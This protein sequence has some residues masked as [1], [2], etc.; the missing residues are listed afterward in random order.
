MSGDQL[1]RA[2]ESG[3]ERD[4]Y[5][6]IVAKV[7]KNSIAH[8]A[9]IK[10]GDRV[11]SINDHILT[12]LIDYN[13]MSPDSNIRVLVERG[14]AELIEFDIEKDYG[15]DLGIE[16][17]TPVFDSISR[18]ANNCIF[19]FMD[20]M[21]EGLRR[22]LYLKDE[23]YRL[24]FLYG[25]FITMT[26]MSEEDFER[27]KAFN[28]SPLYISVHTTNQKLRK[29]IL[30]SHKAE[31]IMKQLEELTSCGIAIHTQVV[32]MPGVNDGEELVK[33]IEDLSYFYP[34]LESIGIV[35]VGLTKYREDLV[36]LRLFT[37]KEAQEVINMVKPFQAKFRRRFDRGLV[38]LADEFYLMC[39]APLPEND[40]YDDFPQ[41]ENGIGIVRSFYEEYRQAKSRIPHKLRY[42]KEY[43][44]VT[45][46]SGELALKNIVHDLNTRVSGLS[47]DIA[48]VENNFFG[49]GVTVTGL[50]T[51]ADLV[52]HFA[53]DKKRVPSHPLLVPKVML[54]GDAF[55]DDMTIDDVAAETGCRIEV[56]GS[57]FESL[58][59]K[60]SEN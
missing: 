41:Y 56:V 40:E 36:D 45:G 53:A 60:I 58:L 49:N 43:T 39:G 25:N 30:R 34:Q 44:I 28:L 20:Q 23:D 5:S 32:L 2:A 24:S 8:G 15:E 7:E 26:R 52:E 31:N 57:D 3:D 47:L 18:C 38:Y 42:S 12:D 6:A 11:V 37:P 10:K 33:T 19:C 17:E 22:S 50:L 13:Y 21:P 46:R 9:G 35:P 16:F 27:V 55:L 14:K 59:S 1:A 29:Q 51:G 4:R 48:C 54:N